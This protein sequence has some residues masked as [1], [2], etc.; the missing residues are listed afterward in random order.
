MGYSVF[1]LLVSFNPLLACRE[2]E[3]YPQGLPVLWTSQAG[4][5]TCIMVP[6]LPLI[7]CVQEG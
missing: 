4:Q 7:W 2:L 1:Y 6:V 3:G 5:D